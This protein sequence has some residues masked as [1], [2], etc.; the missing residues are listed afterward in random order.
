MICFLKRW[1][2]PAALAAAAPSAAVMGPPDASS[3]DA[4]D[5][6]VTRARRPA[7]LVH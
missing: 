2:A 7:A 1:I 5:N 3:P 6:P 4:L